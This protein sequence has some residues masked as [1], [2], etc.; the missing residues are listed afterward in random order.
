MHYVVSLLPRKVTE[1]PVDSDEE[2]ELTLYRWQAL[3][4]GRASALKYTDITCRFPDD[5]PV[6]IHLCEMARI[7]EVNCEEMYQRKSE[8]LQLLYVS[9]ER[10][11][12]QLR[13]C[14][15]RTGIGAMDMGERAK[16]YGDTP[17]L[18]LHNGQPLIR[19][20]MLCGLLIFL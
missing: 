15:E 3:A 13:Q 9:A 20:K 5:R 16:Q 4:M 2:L 10:T 1:W 8:S 6:L 11:Y 7:A 18:H 19:F 14:A 12:A 17:W